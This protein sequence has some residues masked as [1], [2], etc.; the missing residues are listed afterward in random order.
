MWRCPVCAPDRCTLRTA[1]SLVSSRT[2]GAIERRSSARPPSRPGS[3]RVRI[4][5]H[6]L[7]QLPSAAPSL[8]MR[9]PYPRLNVAVVV[10]AGRKPGSVQFTMKVPTLFDDDSLLGDGLSE[11]G[12]VG[13]TRSSPF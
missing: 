8:I 11:G 6:A 10:A 4:A 7:G 3:E 9:L 13:V 12:G 2:A 5:P 1:P